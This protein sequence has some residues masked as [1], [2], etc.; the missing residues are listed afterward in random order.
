[1]EKEKCLWKTN[2]TEYVVDIA[3]REDVIQSKNQFVTNI[4]TIYL[5]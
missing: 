2:F 3:M 5:D 1:M 4:T